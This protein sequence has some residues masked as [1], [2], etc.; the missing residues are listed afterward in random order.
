VIR[1]ER[2]DR[3]GRLYQVVEPSGPDGADVTTTY[4]Y[5]VGNR[6]SGVSTT[7]GVTQVRT[8]TYDQR[9]FLTSEVHPEKTGA[10]TYSGYDAL[11]HA[12]RKVDGPSDLSFVY[13]DA[14][15][16]TEIR[17]TGG[18]LWKSFSYAAANGT[19]DQRKGK[20]QTATRYNR[21]DVL[22]ATPPAPD[23]IFSSGFECGDTSGW[24]GTALSCTLGTEVHYDVDVVETYTYGGKAGRV[25]QRDTAVTLAGTGGETFTQGFSY[26]DL[27][28]VAS[29]SYPR[30]NFT[31]CT[32]DGGGFARTVS[33]TYTRG[34]LTA[35]PG[36]SS[37]I[38]YHPNGLVNRTYHD[39]AARLVQDLDANGMARPSEISAKLSTTTLWT[40]G[41]YSYDGSGNV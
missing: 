9:G 24:D 6:L 17:E 15:R 2:Y 19:D 27:G 8:F 13:D 1:K 21:Y 11:G 26:T 37:T 30:C 4:S 36:Y 25:S 33:F 28:D 3:Q 12:G 29:L 40:T 35:I 31:R 16:L 10:V 34:L 20:L 14:E 41:S 18:D 38:E 23:E 22:V 5:D 32:N 7:S 39:G